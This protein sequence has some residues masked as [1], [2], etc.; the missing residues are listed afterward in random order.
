MNA[1][2]FLG[3]WLGICL[4]SLIT[5]KCIDSVRNDIKQLDAKLNTIQIM[6]SRDELIPHKTVGY[7]L[8]EK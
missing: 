3:L 6:L 5:L 7:K 1:L 8:K 4:L 2:Y